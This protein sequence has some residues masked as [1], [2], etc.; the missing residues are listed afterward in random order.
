MQKSFEDGTRA[1]ALEIVLT[2]STAMPASLRKCDET[3]TM[4]I[5]A[6]VQMMTEVG[7]DDEEWAN[8]IEEKDSNQND[9]YNTSIMAVNKLSVDLGEKNILG[10]FTNMV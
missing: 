9:A 2:L 4:L 3:R 8:K 5:P 6:V 1:S 7:D 10:V